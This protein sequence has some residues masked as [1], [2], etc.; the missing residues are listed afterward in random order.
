MAR[1]HLTQTRTHDANFK[2]LNKR[3]ANNKRKKVRLDPLID[4]WQ[5]NP[6]DLATIANIDT[7]TSTNDSSLP[8]SSLSNDSKIHNL[9]INGN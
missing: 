7:Q 4:A 8:T 1:R 2:S 9:K 3:T 5:P 6:I